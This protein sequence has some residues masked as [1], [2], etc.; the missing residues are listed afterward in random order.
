[1]GFSGL[2]GL[3]YIAFNY[4][5]FP[6]SIAGLVVVDWCV[7]SAL[8]VSFT[9]SI[10]PYSFFRAY[11]Y[12][13]WEEKRWCLGPARGNRRSHG[14]VSTTQR[15]RERERERVLVVPNFVVKD[16]KKTKKNERLTRW[17]ASLLPYPSRVALHLTSH[18]KRRIS[19]KPVAS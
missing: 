8:C 6:A 12:I 10:D 16:A 18:S 4:Y 19:Y 7:G 2:Y 1:M 3:V 9:L 17:T 14:K 13:L 11:W 15:E 5:I